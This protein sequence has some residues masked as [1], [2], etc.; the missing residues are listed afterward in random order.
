MMYE[1][2]E[3]SKRN[4]KII[5]IDLYRD[6]GFWCGVILDYNDDTFQLQH[7]TKFGKKDGVSIDEV[8]KIERI[9]FDDDYVNS[10]NYLIKNQ[11]KL[12]ENK[13]KSRFFED[14]IGDEWQALALT[15]YLNEKKFLLCVSIS[16]S[17]SYRGF[18]E[19]MNEY[20]FSFRCIGDLGEDK[21]LSVF[22]F[23]DVSSIRIN[24]LE[25]RKRFILY[26]K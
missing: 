17:V 2:L 7:Y 13:F 21:G 25:C 22:K 3:E 12:T 16:E 1:L 23:E 6:E 24:D 15:P 11:E 26:K 14:L 10:I 19:K 20:S 4:K 8:A 9:D 18:L 5:G